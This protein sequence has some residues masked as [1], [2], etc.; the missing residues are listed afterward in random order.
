M[1]HLSHTLRIGGVG[2]ALFLILLGGGCSDS[3][4]HSTPSGST[5]ADSEASP[6]V[7]T[8][9][10]HPQIQQPDPGDCPICGMDLIPLAPAG[11]AGGPRTL[12]LSEG[13]RALARL[14]TAEVRRAT[15]QVD[16]RMVGKLEV[17]QTRERTLAARFPGR[18]EQL[19]VNFEGTRVEPGEHLATIYSPE[20]LTAQV[21]L[22][23]ALQ[24]DPEGRAAQAARDK[25]RLWGLPEAEIT[26]VAE[27]GEPSDSLTIYAP[28]GGVVMRKAV[29]EGDYV[30]TGQVLF[31]IVDLS[32][33]WLVLQAYE[34]DIGWIRLGQRAQFT[35]EA[36]PGR[37]FEGVVAFVEPYLDEMTRT[38]EVRVNVANPDGLLK[39]GMLAR[40]H[41][42][43]RVGPEGQVYADYLAG[44]FVSPMHPWIVKDAPGQ[45]D[46]CGMDLVPAAQL[47]YEP[48]P[49]DGEPPLLVP[50]SAVLRTG[51][52]AVVY[53][54]IPAAEEP[55]YEGREIVLG[56]RT[57]EGFIVLG[58]LAA[59]E[60]VVTQGAFK[61]DSSLQIQ[62]RPSMMNPEA[63]PSP[64]SETS[65]PTAL[66]LSPEQG[67]A[68]LPHYLN[69]QNALASDDLAG[70]QEA[71]Q[72]M[73]SLTGH[74][75]PLPDFLHRLL[76]AEDLDALRRP[77]FEQ[78][79]E[80]LIGAVKAEPAAFPPVLQMHCPMVYPDRGADWLQA[81]EPL[82]NPYFGAS[83]LS[84]GE[85][86]ATLGNA[87]ESP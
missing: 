15:P 54:E 14:E 74:H 65:Q 61:I 25:L 79:S 45:C 46:V 13:A 60:R 40:G 59:G 72:N 55:S 83:M 68:I 42:Q 41:V 31:E 12:T 56:P 58:G 22:L 51:K 9:S 82:R 85:T 57:R 18:L 78:L 71:L 2:I 8:C 37:T 7:W 4:P 24:L 38:V 81:G 48:E 34:S 44:K 26:G 5:P 30:E 87:S 76:A 28:V 39:P 73:M 20:L 3:D 75:G 27:R 86:I 49:V 84:C 21:E 19:Y 43:P 11:P 33:L 80:A 6:A 66:Q 35:V 63:A 62:A 53:V 77:H 17:D 1:N 50:A 64:Q 36:Y 16:V 10:M 32:H 47:G 67:L 23:K 70:A 29:N 52:R 69:L